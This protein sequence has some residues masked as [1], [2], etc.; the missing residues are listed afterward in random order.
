[1][2]NHIKKVYCGLL[3]KYYIV[4]KTLAFKKRYKKVNKSLFTTDLNKDILKTYKKKWNVYKGISAEVQTFKLC[5]NLSGIV[6][7][8][9]IPENIFA[10]IIEKEL[11]PYNELHFFQV[12]NIYEKW[13][14]YDDY[15]LFPKSYFHKISGVYYDGDFKIIDNITDFINKT[16]IKF[17]VILKPSKDTFGGAGVSKIYNKNELIEIIQRIEN[18]V[19]QELIH[20]NVYLNKINNNSVNSIRSCLYRTSSGKFKVINNSIRMGIDGGI[21]N[22]TAGGIVCN[23]DESGR[24]N[25]Y[26]CDKYA[27]KYF[28]HPTSNIKFEDIVIPHYQELNDIAEKISNQVPLSNLLSLDMCLD[29]NNKWRCLE[30]N[31]KDHTIRFAQY[32]GKDFFGKYTDEVITKTI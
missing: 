15:N 19:C 13:F 31:T 14:D 9:I 8:K 12:K 7:N 32:A 17:P 16:D 10:A 4:S 21:D 22:E 18:L 24:L 6:N 26:G 20:Q 1:M 30:V 29:S 25:H 23:I 11:N 28:E 5:Y 2:I 27:N 3:R